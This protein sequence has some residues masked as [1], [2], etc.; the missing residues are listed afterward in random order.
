MPPAPENLEP[1]FRNLGRELGIDVPDDL[2]LY[3]Q[4]L[5]PSLDRQDQALFY[6]LTAIPC[7]SGSANGMG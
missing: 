7:R 6:G 1:L 3:F 2:K 5:N 4:L